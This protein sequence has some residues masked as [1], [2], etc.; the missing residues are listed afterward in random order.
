[1]EVSLSVTSIVFYLAL[2]V[3]IK[4]LPNN[5]R[6]PM[7]NHREMMHIVQILELTEKVAPDPL[8]RLG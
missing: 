4:I 3:L 7:N 6:I 8:V 2:G 1:M 5:H